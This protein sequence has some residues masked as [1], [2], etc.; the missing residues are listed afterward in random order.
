LIEYEPLSSPERSNNKNNNNSSSPDERDY[1]NGGGNWGS[2]VSPMQGLNMNLQSAQSLAETLDM[3]KS[4]ATNAVRLLNF[5]Y[6]KLDTDKLLGQGSFS[7]V[8]RGQYKQQE[9]A[10]KLIFT[11]DLTVDVINRVAAESQ[12]LSSLQSVN[13]VN[14]LGVAVLPPRLD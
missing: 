4:R 12:I 8:Y 13:V 14:I 3:L 10:V 2:I 11:V 7:K 5:A 9:C 1:T 6:I